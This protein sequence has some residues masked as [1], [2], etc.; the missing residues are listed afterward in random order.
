[1][2]VDD[3][4]APSSRT[5]LRL[6]NVDISVH[7]HEGY[8]WYTTRKAIEEESKAVRRRLEKIRQL[9]ASGQT[10]D[11]TAENAGVLMFGSHQL[12]LP[13]GADEMAPKDLLAAIDEELER[14][15]KDDDAASTTASSWQ[16]FPGGKTTTETG[17]K[18]STAAT[19][20]VGRNR[21]RLTRSK[22][23]A[24]EVN[25]RGLNTSFD[26][27]SESTSSESSPRPGSTIKV[28]V[29]SFDIIDNIKTSTWRKFLTEMRPSDGGLVRATGSPMARVELETMK[30]IAQVDTAQEEINLKVSYS[31]F[32]LF[33]HA[34]TYSRC[35]I[36][37]QDLASSTLHRPRCT[38]FP[39]SFRSVSSTFI[40]CPIGQAHL[41]KRIGFA[42]TVLP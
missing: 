20:T 30:P 8:D 14:G 25:V 35:T 39:Q 28:D 15:G 36:P 24:I 12:G 32:R 18:K 26:S 31:I 23:F 11:A 7:L 1:M 16:T 34:I 2:R 29:S 3:A 13:P 22:A 10:P 27:F 17:H 40:C 6:T 41:S 33:P 5:R 21:K 19:A 4:S 9:L 38:R 37:D 42:G